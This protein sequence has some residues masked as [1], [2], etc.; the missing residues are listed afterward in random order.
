M[1]RVC[2]P[3]RRERKKTPWSS[4]LMWQHFTHFWFF[5]LFINGSGLC[6]IHATSVFFFLPTATTHGGS[7]ER[8]VTAMAQNL[9]SRTFKRSQLCPGSCVR[10]LVSLHVRNVN[11]LS[12]ALITQ[13]RMCQ[14][15]VFQKL[16]AKKKNLSKAASPHG[17]HWCIM[18]DFDFSVCI[19]YAVF[20]AA[21]W[22]SQLWENCK[23][24]RQDE[25]LGRQKSC[26][27]PFLSTLCPAD[28]HLASWYSSWQKLGAWK[29]L[30]NFWD[31]PCNRTEFFFEKT[32]RGGGKKKVKTKKERRLETVGMERTS[33]RRGTEKNQIAR[34]GKWGEDEYG[35]VRRWKE[36]PDTYRMC[37]FWLLA[38]CAHPEN[39][40]DTSQ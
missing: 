25:L 31:T 10:G 15:L 29:E 21:V 8:G 17:A 12:A 4:P 23:R 26:Q 13:E 9:T 30:F 35:I 5:F 14:F 33:R 18:K 3:S 38:L 40:F 28:I 34:L 19:W 2:F 27:K 36:E 37:W 39:Q 1:E 20:I 6:T 22:E 16:W 32:G 11:S 7:C 24:E